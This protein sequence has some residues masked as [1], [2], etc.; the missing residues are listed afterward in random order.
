MYPFYD[1]TYIVL[2]PA[3]LFS[4]YAQGKI[5]S[6]FDKFLRI[7]SRRGVTG[8]EAARTILDRNGLYDIPVEITRG[9]L[10]DHYDPSKRV[11]RLSNDVYYGDSLAS[12]GVAAHEAGHALQ[13]QQGYAPLSIRNSLVPVANIGSSLSWILIILGFI[14]SPA[15]I[16]LGILLF[17]GVVLFQIVT[18]PVEYNASSRALRQ[19][20]ENFIVAGEEIGGAK[21]VLDAAALTYVAATLVAVSQLLR[22]L[23]LTR[24]SRD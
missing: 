6:T 1:Y 9:H 11:L 19:L 23:I 7:K 8:A 20:E 2:I 21:K 18:L 15:F 3:I 5:K 10:S 22:L 13:H 14:I 17:A 16:N 24:N 12:V 4:L